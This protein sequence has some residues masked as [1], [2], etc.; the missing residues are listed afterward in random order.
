M[1][2]LYRDKVNLNTIYLE[3]KVL[4]SSNNEIL[5]YEYARLDIGYSFKYSYSYT[6]SHI[7]NAKKVE[8]IKDKEGVGFY[9]IQ[10]KNDSNI[11]ALIKTGTKRS[12]TM[13]YGFSEENFYALINKKILTNKEMRMTNTKEA[14]KSQW[15]PNLILMGV[16]LE[17]RA[18]KVLRK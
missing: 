4:Q 8:I 9:H 16:L 5:V 3:Q 14:I 1:K 12:L 18:G 6:L 2:T 17:R 13:V 7:F 15:S 11:Y 10:L